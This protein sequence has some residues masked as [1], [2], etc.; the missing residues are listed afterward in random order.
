MKG[1]N[2]PIDVFL[3]QVAF[4][5]YSVQFQKFGINYEVVV[6]N[7]QKLVEEEERSLLKNRNSDIL[8]KYSRY[9]DVSFGVLA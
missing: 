9:A 6:N 7:F 3:S 4:Q 8:T 5:K 1:F 2:K